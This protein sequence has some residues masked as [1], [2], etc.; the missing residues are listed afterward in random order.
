MTRWSPCADPRYFTTRSRRVESAPSR[1]GRGRSRNRRPYSSN[2]NR[3]SDA[4]TR[5]P[6]MTAVHRGPSTS[7]KDGAIP[8]AESRGW[9]NPKNTL[10]TCPTRRPWPRWCR[11]HSRGRMNILPDRSRPSLRSRFRRCGRCR[12]DLLLGHELIQVK[13]SERTW[14]ELGGALLEHHEHT[15]FVEPVAPAHQ[16]STGAWS[17]L[18]RRAA[19]QRGTTGGQPP[20]R[21]FVQTGDSRWRFGIA[22]ESRTT[23][24]F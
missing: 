24:S 13:P 21:E 22:A 6:V 4:H 7:E 5:S 20:A 19:Y 17:C 10:P 2:P 16:D 3:V 14:R 11:S 18:R 8:R 9:F 12:G 15:G 1:D 23:L